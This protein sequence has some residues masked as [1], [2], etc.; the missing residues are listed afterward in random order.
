MKKLAPLL[1]LTLLAIAGAFFLLRPKPSSGLRPDDMAD[2]GPAADSTAPTSLSASAD[3]GKPKRDPTKIVDEAPA[4]P[5]EPPDGPALTGI[6]LDA[7]TGK[8][9]AGARVSPEPASEPCPKPLRRPHPFLDG[10][11]SAIENSDGTKTT[12]WGRAITTTDKDGQFRVPW[13]DPDAADLYVKAG[14]YVLACSCHVSADVSVIVRLDKGLSIEGVVVT[15]DDMPVAGARV[16][17]NASSPVTGGLGHDE[18]AMTNAEGKFSISGL[19]EG[20]VVVRAD[21]G[22]LFMP[23]AS[24][25]MNPGRKD[26]KLVLIPAF[27]VSFDL[28]T[29]DGRVPETPTVAWTTAG[30]PPR[31]GLEMIHQP[32]DESLMSGS[33]GYQAGG[34]G[35][36]PG[37]AAQA[38]GP[39]R[40]P[41]DRPTVRFEVKALGYSTWTSEPIAIPDIGGATTVPVELRRDPNLGRL[42]VRFEDRDGKPLSYVVERIDPSIWRRDGQQVSAGIVLHRSETLELPAVPSGPYGLMFHSPGHAPVLLE[43]V[44][45]AAGRDT[46]ARAVLGPAAKVR[47]KFTAPE[48]VIVKFRMMLGREIAFPFPERAANAT[49]SSDAGK[50]GPGD[51]SLEADPDGIVLSG[52]ATGRYT[53]EVM[54]PELTAPPTGIDLVEGDI[55]EI[56]IAVS[57]K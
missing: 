33:D 56:E 15:R 52:L 20:S 21:A 38:F 53:V 40:I 9:I 42:I 55:K 10:D 44:D 50:N 47:V 27:A 23:A 45:V 16:W 26:V 13:T 36:I 22:A 24:E 5:T 31:S 14:G 18:M 1:V 7:Q 19:V 48:R 37:F 3:G 41:A 2:A 12:G 54:S 28:K 49:V 32:N 35:K 39:I 30:N 17:T 4:E 34:R 8:P 6:V 57:K 46:E 51:G 29:D 43:K 11:S 25:P